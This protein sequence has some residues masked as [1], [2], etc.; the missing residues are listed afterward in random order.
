MNY[1]LHILIYD[2]VQL[3]NISIDFGLYHNF[4]YSDVLVIYIFALT[5]WGLLI[6][7]RLASLIRVDLRRQEAVST[8]FLF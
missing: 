8:I 2:V 4:E 5:F 6:Y 7:F 3:W 1:I